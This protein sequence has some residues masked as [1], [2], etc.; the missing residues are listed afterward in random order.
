LSGF[1]AW[2]KGRKV[3]LAD[4]RTISWRRARADAKRNQAERAAL[5]AEY[6][7]LFEE[8]RRILTEADPIHI[9]LEQVNPDEY[10]PE[11]GTGCRRNLASL[12]ELSL[13]IAPAE[14]VKL[15]PAL[16]KATNRWDCTTS[17]AQ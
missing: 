12:A 4:G 9:A 5:R 11:V 8:M 15:A 6:N 14:G 3:R 1:F 7:E 16:L 10:E 13:P 17:R 2:L